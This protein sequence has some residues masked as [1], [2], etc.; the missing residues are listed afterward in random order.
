MF[1]SC[2]CHILA[3]LFSS[4]SWCK[5]VRYLDNTDF[6]VNLWHVITVTTIWHRFKAKIWAPVSLL[7][8]IG[9]KL[10]SISSGNIFRIFSVSSKLYYVVAWRDGTKLSPAQ[11][12]C[13][14]TIGPEVVIAVLGWLLF[15][16]PAQLF[17]SWFRLH[18]L[19]LD[20]YRQFH[21][22]FLRVYSSRTT[23]T[24]LK[25][26]YLVFVGF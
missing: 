20:D 2:C 22:E 21:L 9:L 1:F 5:N 25:P 4:E 24:M 12:W 3:K 11:L 16:S 23:I 7:L 17:F 26:T 18:L 6:L 19:L 8:E 10:F 13:V 14:F 15:L